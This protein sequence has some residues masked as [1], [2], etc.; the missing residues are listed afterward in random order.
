MSGE[1]RPDPEFVN[2][3]EWQIKSSLRRRDRFSTPVTSPRRDKMK[4]IAMILVSAFFGAGGVVAKDQVQESRAQEILLTRIEGERRIAEIQLQMVQL[5]YQEIAQRVEEGLVREDML[6]DA[7]LSVREAELHLS[8]LAL[9]EEEVRISGKAPDDDLTAPLV[10]GRDFVTERLEKELEARRTAFATVQRRSNEILE[11]VESG[12]L[13]EENALQARRAME[14]V[15]VQMNGLEERKNLRARFIQGEIT[16]WEAEA[17]S[18]SGEI[19]T[20][21]REHQLTLQQLVRFQ[22]E[23][24]QQVEAGVQPESQLLH[25]RLQIQ[26]LQMQIGTLQRTLEILERSQGPDQR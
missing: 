23:M 4:L 12:L 17:E 1:H 14:S 15:A 16:A 5:N 6:L 22:D 24:A 25:L 11:R 2:Q 26:Q 18:K 20:Q 7:A 19:N 9:S 3:L 21:L 13:Q 8:R 10:G